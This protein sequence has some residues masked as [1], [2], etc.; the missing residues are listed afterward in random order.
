MVEPPL[1]LAI[2][3]VF[4][5]CCS[6]L[7]KTPVRLLLKWHALSMVRN[8]DLF[9]SMLVSFRAAH[10]WLLFT[11]MRSKA[12]DEDDELNELPLPDLELEDVSLPL[13]LSSFRI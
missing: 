9:P 10:Q 1:V 5:G 6:Q 12:G 2:A 7:T 4:F 13:T 11:G 3:Y 8:S